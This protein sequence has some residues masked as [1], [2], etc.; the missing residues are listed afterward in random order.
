MKCQTLLEMR[1]LKFNFLKKF[2]SIFKMNVAFTIYATIPL[3][4]V[5]KDTAKVLFFKE[6]LD[7][8]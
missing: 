5:E 2:C 4:V 7:Y 3:M 8:T 1:N 6:Y